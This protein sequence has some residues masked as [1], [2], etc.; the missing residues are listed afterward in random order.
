MAEQEPVPLAERHPPISWV[1]RRFQ[2]N[3]DALRELVNTLVPQ[4]R[5]LDEKRLGPDALAAVKSLSPEKQE[6]LRRVMREAFEKRRTSPT[7]PNGAGPTDGAEPQSDPLYEQEAVHIDVSHIFK[8]DPHSLM[9]FLEGFDAVMAGPDRVT[10][11][12]NSL[13][14]TGTSALE[15]LLAGVV[16]QYFVVHPGAR[17]SS[18]REFSYSDLA[19][20]ESL[21][22]AADLLI[23]RE[24]TEL[25]HG[26]FE[27][28]AKWFKTRAEADFRRLSIDY[29]GLV[30]IF[31]RRNV[32]MH[33]AGRV[34]RQYLSKVKQVPESVKLGDRLTVDADYLNRAFDQ[35]DALGTLTAVMAWGTWDKKDR[36]VTSFELLQRSYQLLLLERWEA[37]SQICDVGSKL[38]S[39]QAVHHSI[40]CNGW[41]ARKQLEGAAA[42][43]DDV[44]GWDTSALKG[45]YRLAQLVLLDELDDAL[46]LVPHLIESKELSGGELRE[47]P[48][49]EPLRSHGGYA[50]V[51]KRV[52]EPPPGA[53]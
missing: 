13:L 9:R 15:A 17:D 34:S 7:E 11:I 49:L 25:T 1:L 21:D 32:V 42:I 37:V 31:Q 41:L 50:E 19:S 40:R 47:W 5:E 12:H 39:D 10:I 18:E 29:D 28:W 6:E 53:L 51:L 26:D 30:E 38:Q 3:L 36:Q 20:F 33:N 43:D 16:T 4:M 8:D 22:D 24:V 35:L 48:I 46:K 2:L 14:V 52:D 27:E 23:S 44:R 45:Q